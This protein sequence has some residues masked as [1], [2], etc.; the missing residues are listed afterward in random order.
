M[1]C[2][3]GLLFS[4]AYYTHVDGSSSIFSDQAADRAYPTRKEPPHGKPGCIDYEVRKIRM[5]VPG[6]PVPRLR[7]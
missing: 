7:R 4:P 5:T 2:R 6:S 3:G 1:V